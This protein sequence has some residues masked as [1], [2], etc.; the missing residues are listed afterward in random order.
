MVFVA[1]LKLAAFIG[2]GV[3]VPSLAPKNIFNRVL[4]PIPCVSTID[5]STKSTRICDAPINKPVSSKMQKQ[6]IIQSV[7]KYIELANQKF[8]CNLPIPPVEFTTR[9]KCAGKAY[10]IGKLQFNSVIAANATAAGQDF[11]NTI[12]HEIS[13]LVQFKLYPFSKSHGSEFKKIHRLLGGTGET[14]HRYSVEGVTGLHKKYEWVCDCRTHLVGSVK[15]KRMYTG[16]QVGIKFRCSG[17]KTVV[18]P[19]NEF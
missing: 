4:T 1:C 14:Y 15:H 5:T 12:S 16:F 19:K 18:L 11:N 10:R 9:G 6:E 2:V 3:R 7:Q 17:C 8:N 13:H